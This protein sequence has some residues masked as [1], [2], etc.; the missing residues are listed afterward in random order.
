MIETLL[1]TDLESTRPS[2][3]QLI[4]KKPFHRLLTY[5]RPS[6]E[7]KDVPHR[8]KLLGAEP[9]TLSRAKAV[10]KKISEVF[11]ASKFYGL[12]EGGSTDAWS[13]AMAPMGHLLITL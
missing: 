6:L 11:K 10:E 1:L 8:T 13:F 4:D 9:E 12:C 5:L 2:K 7:E 3:F